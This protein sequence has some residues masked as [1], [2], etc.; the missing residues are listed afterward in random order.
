MVPVTAWGI[1]A[2]LGTAQ[3]RIN[4]AETVNVLVALC[5]WSHYVRNCRVNVWVDSSTTK[6]VLTN[7]YSKSAVLTKI[8]GEVWLKAE[9]VQ[10]GLWLHRVPAHLNPADPLSR[11][12]DQILE[13]DSFRKVAPLCSSPEHWR[14]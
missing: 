14:V 4:E 7:G 6:G 2:W 11:G 5:T 13:G 8:A 3:H 9:S 12:D 10:C 1:D